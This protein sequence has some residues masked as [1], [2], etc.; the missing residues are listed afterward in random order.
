MIPITYERI[1]TV[2]IVEVLQ[3]S[4]VDHPPIN[5]EVDF[6][7]AETGGE[8]S[9]VEITFKGSKNVVTVTT[10]PISTKDHWTDYKRFLDATEKRQEFAVDARVIPLVGV[11]YAAFRL[12]KRRNVQHRHNNNF[13]VLTMQLQIVRIF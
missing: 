11:E 6:A 12:D 4:I 3:A 2:G 7:I 1:D 13:F 8:G 10:K 5:P 9:P